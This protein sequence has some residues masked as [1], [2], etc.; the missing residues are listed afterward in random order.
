MSRQKTVAAEV[1]LAEFERWAEGMGLMFDEGDMNDEEQT[2]FK[3][4]KTRIV[5]AIEFGDLVINDNDEAVYTPWRKGSSY[6][7]PITFHE[8]TGATLHASDRGKKEAQKSLLMMADLCRVPT[9]TFNKLVG[10]DLKTCEALYILLM[11]G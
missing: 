6:T 1:A 11:T 3:S 4:H 8:K 2:S 9:S 10:P 7:D 5:G